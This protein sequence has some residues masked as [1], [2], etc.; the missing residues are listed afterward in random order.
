MTRELSFARE[1]TV[2]EK[3]GVSLLKYFVVDALL[4]SRSMGLSSDQPCF[5]EAV[6]IR[7]GKGERFSQSGLVY[8]SDLFAVFGID[9]FRGDFEQNEVRVLEPLAEQESP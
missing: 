8:A 6:D 1:A 3:P 9:D 5:N 7:R 4:G 2:R